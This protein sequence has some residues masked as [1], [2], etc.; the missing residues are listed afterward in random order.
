MGLPRL[1]LVGGRT[2]RH[3]WGN[4]AGVVCSR[5]QR[6]RDPGLRRPRLC[7]TS[8]TDEVGTHPP[9]TPRSGT[10]GREREPAAAARATARPAVLSGR[11]PPPTPGLA[12][13][14]RASPGR[15][16]PTSR[17][18]SAPWK[19]Q[20]G[21]PAPGGP[22][23]RPWL[24]GGLLVA[25]QLSGREGDVRTRKQRADA[26]GGRP[27]PVG[28]GPGRKAGWPEVADTRAAVAVVAAAAPAAPSGSSSGWPK[29]AALPAQ[30]FLSPSQWA[31]PQKKGGGCARSQR[32][33]EE[34]GGD[35]LDSH[36]PSSVRPSGV[37]PPR[38]RP[39]PLVLTPEGGGERGLRKRS[40]VPRLPAEL[41]RK[42]ARCFLRVDSVQNCRSW[43]LN[44]F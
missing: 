21:R 29:M 1:G 3:A 13:A 26:A 6:R 37:D 15:R 24:P 30:G 22:C 44:Y 20:A 39:A 11:R 34:G 9:R 12:A 38:P 28:Q 2:A 35:R 8:R 10:A 40:C 25:G 14:C 16:P 23:G 41:L 17:L 27:E 43:T 42:F 19:G 31:G 32:S 18:A 33:P 36:A 5:G 4:T 7:P